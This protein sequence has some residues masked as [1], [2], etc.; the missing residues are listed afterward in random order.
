M[1]IGKNSLK[2]VANGGYAN[3]KSE[4]PDMANSTVIPGTSSEVIAMVEREASNG[5][6]E[7]KPTAKKTAA[8]KKSAAKKPTEK[9]A[10]ATTDKKEIDGFVRTSLGDAMPYYLL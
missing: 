5:T 4:S 7:K 3:I 6:A 1:P 2:R 9:K 8:T 10:E